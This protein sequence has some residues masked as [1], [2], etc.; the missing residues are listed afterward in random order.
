MGSFVESVAA[1]RVARVLITGGP[2]TPPSPP[3]ETKVLRAGDGVAHAR[4]TDSDLGVACGCKHTCV[5]SDWA[6]AMSGQENS[7]KVSCV[8]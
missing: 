2:V 5:S 1:S 4:Q 3:G 7:C 8:C 6:V